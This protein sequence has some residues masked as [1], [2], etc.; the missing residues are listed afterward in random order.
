MRLSVVVFVLVALSLPHLVA[1]EKPNILLIV[2]EDNGPEFGCYGDANAVANNITPTLDQLARDG[3]MFRSAFVPYSV[4]SPSR[5]CFYTGTHVAQNGH[6]GLQTHKFAMYEAYPTIYSLLRDAGYRTGLIG[7]LHINP[8]NAVSDHVDYRAITS[9]NFGQSS[10]NMRNYA[11]KANDFITGNYTGA[12]LGKPFLLTINYPDAH[13]PMHHLAPTS[14]TADADTLPKDPVSWE[15][16]QVIPWMGVSSQRLRDQTAG[17]Y[18]C[19]Q[20]LDDGIAM[21]LADL[22][23]AGHASDTLI[24]YIGDHGAQFSRGKTSCYEAGLRVPMIVKWP[25]NTADLPGEFNVCEELASTTDILPTMLTAAAVEI[26]AHCSGYPLQPLLLGQE[27]PWRLYIFG[28]TTGSA[29]SIH[30]IQ[31]SVRDERYKLIYNPF[32]DPTMPASLRTLQNRCA[33][34]YLGGS[35]HFAAGATQAEIDDPSTPVHVQA[36]YA[37]YLD[38]PLYELYDL[39]ADPDEWFDLAADPSHAVV[40]QRL[41][42]ALAAWQDDPLIADPWGELANVEHFGQMMEDAIGTNYNSDSSFIWDYLERVIPWNYPAWRAANFPVFVPPAPAVLHANGFEQGDGFTFPT[43][44][45]FVVF[46]ASPVTDAWGGVWTGDGGLSGVW[47]RSDIPPEGVQALRIGTASGSATSWAEV[48]LPAAL[49][50]VGSVDFS[51]ANYSTSTNCTGRVYLRSQ[52]NGTWGTPIW[53]QAF[54]GLQVDW[55][56]KPWPFANITVDR[57]D[58]PFELRYETVG[59]KGVKFDQFT[60][61]E[62]VPDDSQDFEA[63]RAATF[64]AADLADPL[65]S[66]GDRDPEGDGMTNWL[67]FLLGKDPLAVEQWYEAIDVGDD[68]Y[69]TLEFTLNGRASEGATTLEMSEDLEGWSRLGRVRMTGQDVDGVQSMQVEIPPMEGSRLF[70][71]IDGG[72]AE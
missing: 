43:T 6:E 57:T 33:T 30:Y 10:R 31:L 41:I 16:V 23:V 69:A 54:S 55:K 45:D 39:Q 42:D 27:V 25:G 65:V 58:G 67:E 28:H 52:G 59:V 49:T 4:C 48:E 66:G 40:K 5:A 11:E 22:A 14:S 13:L 21:V 44:G 19:L 60:V 18:N 70:L 72:G 61:S 17:Y 3:V 71:R 56:V 20:R 37:R 62:I 36:A 34:A 29:P 8:G 9:S 35:G 26:P 63:W 50:E 12:D 7:K 2:S 46:P 68:G 38:P 47:N 53:E 24:I 64:S 32:K 15:D 1:A 51:Y